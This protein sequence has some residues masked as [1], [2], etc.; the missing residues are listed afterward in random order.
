MTHA[1]VTYYS[2]GGHTARIAR[3]ICETLRS[4][5]ATC[6]MMDMMEVVREGVVWEKYD[7][8]IVGAAVIYGVYNKIVLE[9]VRRFEHQLETTPSSFFN[10][11]VVAR[12]PYKATIEGNRYMQRFLQ[13]SPW[14]PTDLKCFAG[15]V[16][17]PNWTWYQ[18][19]AIQMIMKMTKGPTDPTTVIDYTDWEDV[20]AYARHCLMLVA[21][22]KKPAQDPEKRPEKP[23]GVPT[24]EAKP[25][26]KPRSSRAEATVESKPATRRAKAPSKRKSTP[27]ASKKTTSKKVVTESEKATS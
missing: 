4:E 24:S 15:K 12:R 19:L 3:V 5:G 2:H 13:K 20:K 17:Y 27:K 22:E 23:T 16:D 10:V 1:L 8:I 21:S 18:K 7:L 6:D 25:L 14:H 11:T 9:F 26:K